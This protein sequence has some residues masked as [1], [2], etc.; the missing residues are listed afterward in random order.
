M[1]DGQVRRA[2]RN[3]DRSPLGPPP[4]VVSRS[5]V[6][7][8]RLV[9]ECDTLENLFEMTCLPL[10][11]RATEDS[12]GEGFRSFLP[13][14]P[15]SP[16][17]RTLQL[18]SRSARSPWSGSIKNDL[19][20][21]YSPHP[22]FPF[23]RTPLP[24]SSSSSTRR[25]PTALS[26]SLLFTTRPTTLLLPLIRCRLLPTYSTRMV[27]SVSRILRPSLPGGLRF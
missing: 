22:H 27:S 24:S 15:A 5:M 16:S 10:A 18:S 9:V 25:R 20:T 21:P 23:S 13:S 8:N 11:C 17:A 1:I 6:L 2:V 4:S 19:V 12:R 14:L 26:F 3:E 7:A